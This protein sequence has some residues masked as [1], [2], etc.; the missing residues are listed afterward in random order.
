MLFY[1]K[2]VHALAIIFVP[3]RFHL[4][5]VL[6]FNSIIAMEKFRCEPSHS[7]NNHYHRL[8]FCSIGKS[9]GKHFLFVYVDTKETTFSKTSCMAG[10]G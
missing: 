6:S 9:I 4:Q 1:S 5:P 7:I 2:I 8:R 3:H 10:A